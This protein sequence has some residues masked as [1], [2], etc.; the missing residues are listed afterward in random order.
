V[1]R[2]HAAWNQSAL[3]RWFAD[4]EF[5]ATFE[6]LLAATRHGAADAVEVLETAARVTDGDAD[7]WMDEWAATAG[8]AWEQA[9]AAGLALHPISARQHHLRAATYY[10]VA[11]GL[12]GRSQEPERAAALL[13]RERECWEEAIEGFAV[14][15][16]PG[17]FF[18]TPGVAGRGAVVIVDTGG[19]GP[20][21][22]WSRAG[23]AARRR[24]HHWVTLDDA[25]LSEL[26]DVLGERPD[27]DPRRIALVALGAGGA[28][29]PQRLATE[30][31]LAA[32]VADPA[33]PVARAVIDVV[34]TPLLLCG[35]LARL[36]SSTHPRIEEP[37]SPSVRESA[38]FDWL[39]AYLVRGPGGQ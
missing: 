35:P 27:A 28:S 5:Q 39:E 3:P 37:V 32:A 9:H 2:V 4:Q 22:S 20:A 23:A 26:I 38:I 33:A 15:L 1:N 6:F 13:D 17:H 36:V 21:L 12:V 30:R 25:P 24:G 14:A 18:P 16:E 11:G 7:S 8:T 19:A 34:R 29:L 10:G 31:R